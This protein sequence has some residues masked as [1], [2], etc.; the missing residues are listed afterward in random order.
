M[1]LPSGLLADHGGDDH[2]GGEAENAAKQGIH[3]HHRA[4]RRKLEG[5]PPVGASP[6]LDGSYSEL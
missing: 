1:L 6:E 2:T 3:A 5:A 4:K